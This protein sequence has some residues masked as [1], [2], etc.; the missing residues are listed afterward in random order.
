M[1]Q[2][3]I[4][5]RLAVAY[6]EI[7][8]LPENKYLEE[9]RTPFDIFDPV[10]FNQLITGFLCK[11]DVGTFIRSSFS[12]HKIVMLGKVI[13]DG[14]YFP[15]NL[16]AL[17]GCLNGLGKDV[18]SLAYDLPIVTKEGLWAS[19]AVKK[20]IKSS[21]LDDN[22]NKQMLK[23]ALK[24]AART[25][26]GDLLRFLKDEWGLTDEDAR[27]HDNYALRWAAANGHVEV[28]RFLKDEWG[29]TDEDARAGD[30]CALKV[31]AQNGHVEV[32][33]FL[34]DEW[35]LTAHDARTDDNYALKVAAQKGHVE[36]LKVLIDEFQ[37]NLTK[38][39]ISRL[40]QIATDSNRQSVLDYFNRKFTSLSA[41]CCVLS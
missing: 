26:N 16:P 23:E 41:S 17:Y 30:N 14:A 22:E 5:K 7:K 28:L 19:A 24:Y 4:Y 21:T 39:E 34:K 15:K 37:I 27:A 11:H 32:L 25:G 33:R 9:V 38:A 29:L 6:R 2:Q 18:G 40:K 3:I 20:Y 8:R 36:V 13:T 12:V 1:K 35:G 10:L 31:A